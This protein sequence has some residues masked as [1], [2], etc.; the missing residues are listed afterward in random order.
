MAVVSPR[1]QA[2]ILEQQKGVGSAFMSVPPSIPLRTFL[3]PEQY[4][5]GLRWWLGLPLVP[6]DETPLTCPGC[7]SEA[8]PF[9]DHVLCCGQNDFRRRHDA[10]VEALNSALVTS[11]QGVQKEVRVPGMESDP[12]FRPADLL[13]SAWQGGKDMA[14][15]VTVRHAWA[16]AERAPAKDPQVAREHWRAFLRRQEESKHRKYDGPCK[17][18]DWG[19]TAMALGTWGGIGPEGE[20]CLRR[21]L[22]RVG[23][24]YEGSLRAAKAEEVRLQ[25]GLALMRGILDLLYNKNFLR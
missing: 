23:G 22:Q 1:D 6:E 18:A 12:N 17:K 2:R 10:V 20:R 24:W 9:G 4:R 5:L 16:Q 13:L 25:V 19:F 3:S 7:G 8:D 11:V 21:I 15:D 14:V